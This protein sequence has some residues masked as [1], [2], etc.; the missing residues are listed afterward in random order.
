MAWDFL[1]WVISKLLSL[2]IASMASDHHG[3][4]NGDPNPRIGVKITPP[5][6]KIHFS[7]LTKS[8]QVSAVMYKMA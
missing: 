7:L 5:R 4:N 8:R 1:A 3:K 2:Q 6:L